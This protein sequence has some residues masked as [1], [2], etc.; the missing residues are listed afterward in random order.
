MKPDPLNY[1]YPSQRSGGDLVINGKAF[2]RS[3]HDRR[4]EWVFTQTFF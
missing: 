2:R 3:D 4:K 1:P